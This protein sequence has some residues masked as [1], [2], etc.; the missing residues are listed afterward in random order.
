[1][2][3]GHGMGQMMGTMSQASLVWLITVVSVIGI[4][5]FTAY[6]VAFPE[7]KSTHQVATSESYDVALRFLKEDEKRVVEALRNSKNELLQKDIVKQM[8]LSK[9]KTHR[10]IARLAER[11]I[12]LAQR[13]GR[14]NRVKLLIQ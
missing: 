2:T 8:G 12:V 4:V 11:G 1:M 9:I 5:G 7:I 10:V 3:Q 14:T 6:Y 13:E